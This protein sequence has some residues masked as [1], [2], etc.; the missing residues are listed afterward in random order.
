MKIVG[1]VPELV[2][3]FKEIQK[4]PEEITA[5]IWKMENS[6]QM[7]YCCDKIYGSLIP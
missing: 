4:Q 1:S 6:E 3:A 7:V 2:E 5:V